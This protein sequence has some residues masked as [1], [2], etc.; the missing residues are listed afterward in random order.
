MPKPCDLQINIDGQQIFLL[1][2]KVISKYCGGLKKILNHRKRRGHVKQELGIRINDFPG[3]P[4]GF[5]LVSM[6]CYNNGKIQITEANVCLLHCCAVYLGMTEE[7][8]S[9]NL[10]QQTETFLQGIFNWKWSDTLMILKSC[11][12]FHAYADGYGLLEKIISVLAKFVQNSDSNLLMSSPSASASSSSS[13]PETNSA[14]R[15]SFSSKKTTPEKIKSTLSRKAWWFDDLA[16][17]PPNII[18]KLVQATGAYKADNKDLVLTRF[19]LHYLKLATQ[20]RVVN[21]SNNSEYA[22]LAETATYGVISVGKKT[23][24]CRGLFWVLRIVSKFGLGRDVRTELEKLI[25]GV[26]EQATLDDLLVSGHDMGVYYDIN[27]VIRL[28]RVFVD[29][30][31]SDE[32]MCLQ[33][34]KRVGRLID[35]Y[36][37]EISPDQNLKISKFLGVAECLPDSARDCYDGVYKAIDIYLQSHPIITFEER[38][39]LCRCLNYTKLTF[40]ASKDLAKNP[41]IPPRVAMQALISQQSKVPTIDY[42]TESPRVKPSQLVLYNGKTRNSF[43]KEKKEME[44]NIDKMQW[45]VIELAKLHKE[46]NGHVSKLILLD[47]PRTSSSPRFC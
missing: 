1:K 10:L 33:K 21:C 6:F 30:N 16:T 38:S 28:V 9:N 24:S 47:P 46:M 17:L 22:A 40:E 13:S 7:V 34:L 39:R 19:L 31:G 32:G 45:G 11:E 41:R 5:E 29:M 8:L 18:E 35:K 37:R 44:L 14:K 23:F 2:E 25:G 42:V 3:G 27:L 36:L 26:I 15:F 20:T 4:E 12:R 43:T